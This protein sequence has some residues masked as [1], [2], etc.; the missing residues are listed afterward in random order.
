MFFS[1]LDSRKLHTY[2]KFLVVLVFYFYLDLLFFASFYFKVK[3]DSSAE[4]SIRPVGWSTGRRKDVADVVE[5]KDEQKY[6]RMRIYK[7]H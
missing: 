4:N 6:S 3:I 7:Q 1:S 5:D 2:L